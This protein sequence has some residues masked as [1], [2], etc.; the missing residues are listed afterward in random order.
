MA[1]LF[2]SFIHRH[3]EAFSTEPLKN[4]GR[5]PPLGFYHVQNV[6]IQSY[7]EQIS[8]DTNNCVRA[9]LKMS[10][11]SSLVD[12]SGGDQVLRGVHQDS[13]HRLRGVRS[14]SE[15]ALPSALQ[16]PHQVSRHLTFNFHQLIFQKVS[17][18]LV[19][20]SFFFFSPLRP[21]RRQFP[22]VMPLSKPGKQ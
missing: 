8:L 5:G 4:T 11:P 15:T 20:L 21:S 10:F 14:L 6:N 9:V 22:R 13:A 18:Y 19:S 17:Q 1:S 2:S 16:R 7:Y 3:D 12:H